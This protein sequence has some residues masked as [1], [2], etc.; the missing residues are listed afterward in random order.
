MTIHSS[1]GLAS[2]RNFVSCF[3]GLLWG[4]NEFACVVRRGT[5]WE[6]R[7]LS[8]LVLAI[9][10]AKNSATFV[11]FEPLAKT[12]GLSIPHRREVPGIRVLATE[13]RE[14]TSWTI[15][16][17]VLKGCRLALMHHRMAFGN[18]YPSSWSFRSLLGRFAV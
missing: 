9:F 2:G 16:G 1:S 14:R 6:S 13:F 7:V 3:C 8:V 10:F 11:F 15:L 5:A 18:D 17:E 4:R 12:S